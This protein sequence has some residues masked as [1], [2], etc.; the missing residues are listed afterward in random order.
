MT[1]TQAN[2]IAQSLVERMRPFCERIEV[3]GSLR[4]S[5]PE[6]KDIELV[7][8]P[9]WEEREV[10]AGLFDEVETIRVNTLFEWA[11]GDAAKDALTWIK[12]ATSDIVPWLPKADGRYWRAIVP[13]ERIKV[14]VFICTPHNWGAIYLVRTGSREFV[15]QV[16]ARAKQIGCN[17]DDGSF[18]WRGAPRDTPEEKDVFRLLR[19]KPVKPSQRRDA[20]DV[21]IVPGRGL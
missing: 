20:R 1:H 6:V 5:V 18:T 11:T 10:K 2:T 14:D 16:A 19:I 17:L 21:V 15:R 13:G 4:R 3:A 12:P 7:V 8:I 9:K